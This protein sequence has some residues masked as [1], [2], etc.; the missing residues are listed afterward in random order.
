MLG[1]AVNVT[2]H[3]KEDTKT[4]QARDKV[5]CFIQALTWVLEEGASS[6]SIEARITALREEANLEPK[7]AVQDLAG[8]LMDS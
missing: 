7:S 6:D 5:Y 3:M 1:K 4:R 2:P 8:R